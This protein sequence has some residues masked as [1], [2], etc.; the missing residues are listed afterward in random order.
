MIITD[1]ETSGFTPLYK[2]GEWLV[3]S[4]GYK[5]GVNDVASVT[6]MGRHMTTN[7]VFILLEGN[8]VLLSAEKSSSIG[9]I[10]GELM[11]PK[12]LYT[13]EK[14]EWHVIAFAEKSTALIVEN[15]YSA[16]EDNM[17]SDMT[18]EQIRRGT[19]I[20]LELLKME[21]KKDV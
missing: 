14:G 18:P 21:G 12:R 5:T 9:E 4:N 15:S 1:I 3:A 17:I 7:E 13:V 2:G 11:V 8:A 16:Q 6:T 20:V 19:E 10:S